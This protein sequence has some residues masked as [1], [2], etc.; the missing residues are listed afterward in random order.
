MGFDSVETSVLFAPH[1]MPVYR[2]KSVGARD[3]G[4]IDRQQTTDRAV[5][6]SPIA[7]ALWAPILSLGAFGLIRN[8]S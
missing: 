4:P 1:L 7:F 6:I 2:R 5:T 3:H 8:L